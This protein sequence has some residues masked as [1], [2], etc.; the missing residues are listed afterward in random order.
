MNIKNTTKASS[1]SKIKESWMK[2]LK[3]W[4]KNCDELSKAF[5]CM[6][7]KERRKNQ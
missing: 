6:H 3:K 1:K 7:A 2:N 5:S 4:Q